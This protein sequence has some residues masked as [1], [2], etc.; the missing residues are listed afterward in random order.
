MV[1]KVPVQWE[2]IS[3]QETENTYNEV[4]KEY[5]EGE[6]APLAETAREAKNYGI[7]SMV[8]NADGEYII[9]S[10]SSANSGFKVEIFEPKTAHQLKAEWSALLLER[11]LEVA[12]DTKVSLRKYWGL[13]SDVLEIRVCVWAR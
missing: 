3:L 6:T 4:T 8:T 2:H 13:K 10:S 7:A 12:A 1:Y 5:K 11:G 9:F